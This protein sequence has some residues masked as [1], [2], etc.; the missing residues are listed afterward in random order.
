MC[1]M[2][3]E[4]EARKDKG[5]DPALEIPEELPWLHSCVDHVRLILGSWPKEVQENKFMSV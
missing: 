5:M 3:C 1:W 2:G 4:P